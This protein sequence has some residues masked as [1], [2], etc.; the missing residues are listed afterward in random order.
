MEKNNK[1]L[2]IAFLLLFSGFV[3]AQVLES[4]TIEV[5]KDRTTVSVVWSP[6]PYAR[7]YRLSY[8]PF[9]YVGASSIQ[10]IDMGDATSLSATLWDGAS[11]YVAVT[12]YDDSASSGFSNIELFFLSAA[13]V[14]NPDALPVTGGSWYKPQV[15]ISWQ[16][17]L[18]GEVNSD[19]PVELY[20]I[21]LF[22]SPATL[23]QTLKASGKKVICYFSAG[24]YENFRED[25]HKFDPVVL[26]NTLD[27]WP[28]EQWLDIRSLAVAEIMINR[29]DLALQKG[30][31]G[32]EPDNMDGYLNASGFDLTARDQLAFNKLIANEAHKRSLSVGLKN[33]LEQIPELID[34]YDFSVNEQCHEYDECDALEPFIQAGKPVLNA[35]YLQKYSADANER[36]SLCNAANHARFSTLILPL[37]LDDSFRLSCLGER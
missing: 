3:G 22:D 11:F 29:L 10:T 12:A 31:D 9:P 35:E 33:D 7:G 30:C 26:G 34:F 19:Y 16:W 17:Q 2:L 21:D 32:V 1:F 8:A 20:D 5:T 6:V 25:Q 28:N 23:I 4:P 15:S 13:P 18:N 14:L 36:D 27:G 37:D 24:S